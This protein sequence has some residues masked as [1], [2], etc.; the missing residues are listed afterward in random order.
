MH[1]LFLMWYR[2]LFFT[3]AGAFISSVNQKWASTSNC[4]NHAKT[5]LETE[6][7]NLRIGMFLSPYSFLLSF[8]TRSTW[9]CSAVGNISSA[10]QHI[11]YW[12]CCLKIYSQQPVVLSYKYR[13]PLDQ[14]S[15]S[16]LWYFPVWPL[17]CCASPD[18]D[19][20]IKKKKSFLKNQIEWFR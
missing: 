16:A 17:K 9:Q 15:Y 4:K 7:S 18:T 14:L 20:W 2:L 3:L 19:S 1:K 10:A 8:S 13:K 5:P 6:D 12:F 11:H